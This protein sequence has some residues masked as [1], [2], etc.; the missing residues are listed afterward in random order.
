MVH[1]GGQLEKNDKRKKNPGES[2]W[3]YKKY[4]YMYIYMYTLYMYV[5]MYMYNVAF[6]D[7]VFQI[8]PPLFLRMKQ[9]GKSGC[10]N[11]RTSPLGFRVGIACPTI[12]GLY[13]WRPAFSIADAGLVH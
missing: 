6:D 3:F 12:L 2:N 7:N 9:T 8:N 4:M 11:Y 1:E 5:Y 13:Y 10:K